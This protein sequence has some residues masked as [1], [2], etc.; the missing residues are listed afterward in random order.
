[1]QLSSL[2]ELPLSLGI[3]EYTP[4]HS[5]SKQQSWGGC[6]SISSF[7]SLVFPSTQYSTYPLSLISF[8]EE[9]RNSTL[10][11]SFISKYQEEVIALPKRVLLVKKGKNKPCSDTQLLETRNIQFKDKR[12]QRYF[13]KQKLKLSSIWSPF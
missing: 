13:R 4:C 1:M 11:F 12:S 10:C 5:K 8:F 3:T 6:I 2:W 9:S 7:K